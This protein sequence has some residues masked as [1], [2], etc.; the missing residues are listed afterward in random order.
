VTLRQG[1]LELSVIEVRSLIAVNERL[2]GE[3]ERVRRIEDK[4]APSSIPLW[5]ML[6]S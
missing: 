4:E 6:S 1:E 5:G 2:S 3:T